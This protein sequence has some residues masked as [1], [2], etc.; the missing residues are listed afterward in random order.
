MLTICPEKTNRGLNQNQFFL[1][2]ERT[3]STLAHDVVPQGTSRGW[4]KINFSYVLKGQV[5]H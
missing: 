4:I 3:S 5:Q 2:P 1:C